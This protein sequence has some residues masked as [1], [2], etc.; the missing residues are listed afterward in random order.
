[1]TRFVCILLLLCAGCIQPGVNPVPPVPPT[2]VVDDPATVAHGAVVAYSQLAAEACEKTAGEITADSKAHEVYKIL[3]ER[4]DAAREAAMSAIGERV[5]NPA[6]AEDWQ[7][8]RAKQI[9]N[10]LARGFRAVR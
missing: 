9:L 6:L 4:N 8:E 10:E 7:P 5:L 3:G 2:P 1:M